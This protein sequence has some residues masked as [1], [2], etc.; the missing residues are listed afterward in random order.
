MQGCSLAHVHIA[1]D[2]RVHRAPRDP[3]P[4]HVERDADIE[5]VVV[6]LAL[7]DAEEPKVV[8]TA[9]KRSSQERHKRAVADAAC[10]GLIAAVKDVC[11]AL[12]RQRDCQVKTAQQQGEG[13]R[14]P[15]QVFFARPVLSSAP[16]TAP[17]RSSTDSKV[18]HRSLNCLSRRTSSATESGGSSA[19]KGT[20]PTA[21]WLYAGVRGACRPGMES[22]SAQNGRGGGHEGE[23][24]GGD[25]GRRTPRRRRHGVVGRSD[26]G[27]DVKGLP[28]AHPR[29]DVVQEL[30]RRC[31]QQRTV[32]RT[33]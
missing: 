10:R 18:R 31:W 9:S 13:G 15:A 33:A 26:A 12:F 22:A 19:M 14:G 25:R 11:A 32:V 4:P 27:D 28:V 20:W 5:V 1:A 6:L 17:T 7:P 21:E 3:W 16:T 30:H 23:G 2:V 8:P 29:R 24:E